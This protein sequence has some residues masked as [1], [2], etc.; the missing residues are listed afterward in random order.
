MCILHAQNVHSVTKIPTP[1]PKCP[2]RY[3][4]SSNGVDSDEFCHTQFILNAIGNV[5]LYRSQTSDTE[6]NVILKK[7]FPSACPIHQL[8]N[9]LP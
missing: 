4:I 3:P 9:T 5:L 2:L 8:F 7:S 1:L 6:Y